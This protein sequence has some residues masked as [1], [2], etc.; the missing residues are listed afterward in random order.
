MASKFFSSF[1]MKQFGITL[2]ESVTRLDRM[3]PSAETGERSKI[4]FIDKKQ[5]IRDEEI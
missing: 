2:F 3:D 5:E 1:S 4:K